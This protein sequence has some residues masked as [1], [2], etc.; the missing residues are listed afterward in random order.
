MP[1]AACRLQYHK[2]LAMKFN[3]LRSLLKIRTRS[4][5]LL[6]LMLGI[7]S[8]ALGQ[9]STYTFT[10]ASG[11]YSAISG[12]TTLGTTSNDDEIW[13][14]LSIGFTFS[15]NGVAYTQFGL[16]VNG[17]IMLGSGTPADSKTPISD[18]ANHNL[19]SALALDLQGQGSSSIQYLVTG[20]APN[21]TLVIQWQNYQR[22]DQYNNYTDAVNF[23]IRLNE[24]SNT[25]VFR[26]GSFTISS[27][28]NSTAEVGLAG[29]SSSDYNNRLVTTTTYTT[30]ANSGPGSANNSNCRLRSSVLPA[31]GQSYTWTSPCTTPS[32]TTQPISK[33]ACNGLPV[34]FSVDASGTGLTYQWR[35]G[36]TDIGGATSSSYT[37][38]PVA[39]GDAATNYNVLITND[40]GSSVTSNDV[41]LTVHSNP[42]ASVTGQKNIT[43]K[44]GNDGTITVTASGGSGTGYSFSKDGSSYEGS[45]NPYTFINLIANTLYKIRVKDSNGCQSPAIP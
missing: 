42:S 10:Q 37:I 3:C 28:M 23:Q 6:I 5:L 21:R 26:Y 31:S 24:T 16:S 8:L 41:S 1:T 30:W 35:K 32:I 43:C 39:A 18:G 34:T 38:N 4:A 2:I 45:G 44:A 7:S 36:T 29:S 22:Y 14:N 9:V 40:C 20:T 13:G 19:I 33:S 17:W 25:I 15:F 11:T 12:G 27:S